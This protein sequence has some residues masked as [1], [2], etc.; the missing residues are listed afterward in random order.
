MQGSGNHLPLIIISVLFF[1]W[2]M[3]TAML[4]EAVPTAKAALSEDWISVC[5][6][7]MMAEQSSYRA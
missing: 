4:N 7:P 3:Q 5:N 1:H 2:E 6:S